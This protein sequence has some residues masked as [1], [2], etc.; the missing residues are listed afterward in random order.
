M[1]YVDIYRMQFTNDKRQDVIVHISDTISGIGAPVFHDLQDTDGNE[2]IISAK[3][4]TAND[5]EDKLSIIRSTRFTCQF[6]STD[7]YNVD[8]FVEG[9]DNRWLVEVF[10]GATTN[11]PIF[12]GYLVPEGAKDVFLPHGTYGVELTASD[13]LQSIGEQPLRNGT[14]I[15]K[16]KYS[17]IT[18]VSWCLSRTFLQLPIKVVY[19]LRDENHSGADDHFFKMIYEEALSFES[20]INE[21]EDCLTVLKKILLGCFITQV[22][23]EWW[24]VRVDEMDNTSYRIA[25]FNSDGT[26]ISTTTTNY[27]KFIGL[28]ETISIINED[29]AIFPE[30]K[31]QFARQEFRFETWQ[32]IICNIN[33]TRGTLNGSITVPSGYQ[34]LNPVECWTNGRNPDGSAG[35]APDV[36]GYIRKKITNGYEE[37]RILVLPQT[38][39][40]GT[41]HLHYWQ[42]D[43]VDVN[44]LDKFNFSVDRK[45]TSDH[46]GSGWFNDSIFKIRLR[47]NDGS[48][49]A[50]IGNPNFGRMGSWKQGTGGFPVQHFEWIYQTTAEDESQWTTHS[51]EVD[52]CPVDGK[53]DIML[54]QSG[55]Y[56]NVNDT[57][58]A[59]IQ[60]DYIPIIDGVYQKVTGQE[61][62][63]SNTE[64]RK[65]NK[66]EQI[67]ISDAVSPNWKGVLFRSTGTA[68][69]RVNRVYDYRLGTTGALGLDRFGAYQDF[70]LWNQY[71][72]TIRKFQANLEG[73]DADTQ[74]PTMIHKFYFTDSSLATDSKIYQ[75]LNFDMDLA[76]CQWSGT[77]GDVYDTADGKEY[78]SAHQFKYLT[79]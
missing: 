51:L 73:L 21:R 11:P 65:A 44:K 10:I 29:A 25:S 34:A 41:S 46:T 2:L 52:P 19:N 49:W 18:Y 39:T 53:V 61:H 23:S 63:V 78:T 59:N 79:K 14:A 28:N 6:L 57:H 67:F 3:L 7:T 60:F 66:D 13:L 32:E 8:F 43:T 47:G 5:G 20:E 75:L 36:P 40:S 12:T 4:S 62:K 54:F 58:F 16:G 30:R 31:V 15:P 64:N 1:S 37:E 77:F 68:Y 38:S 48:Y 9:Q 74:I 17:L 50:V 55:L 33:Y 70:A 69:V 24:I 56:Y 76:T 35:A 72:R 27:T 71:N 42:S 45:L 22:N 26:Y